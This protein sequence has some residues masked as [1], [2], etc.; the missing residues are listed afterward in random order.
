MSWLAASAV[1]VA[2]SASGDLAGYGL[3][4]AIEAAADFPSSLSGLLL[5]LL[6]SL[7][8]DL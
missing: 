4:V 5:A 2:S 3:G 7:C 1:V 8:S 6:L